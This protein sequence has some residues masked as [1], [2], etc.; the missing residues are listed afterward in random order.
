MRRIRRTAAALA[1]IPLAV[2]GPGEPASEGTSEE[3]GGPVL[4]AQGIYGRTPASVG[5]I[6]SVIMLTPQD[7]E[8]GIPDASQLSVTIDQFGL[9]FSPTRVV[10]KPGAHVVFS[11]S[12]AAVAHNVRVRAVGDTVDVLDADAN[13]G[14]RLTVELPSPGG[15]DVLCDMHPGMTAFIFV[16]DAAHAAFA[17]ADGAFVL[18]GVAPGTYTVQLWTADGGLHEDRPIEVGTGRTGIDLGLTG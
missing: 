11:N 4:P 10:T 5:G 15:Y 12:E 1:A 6:P 2:C 7:D 16:S 14:E 9:T 3:A 8:T 13:P 18:E 17:E